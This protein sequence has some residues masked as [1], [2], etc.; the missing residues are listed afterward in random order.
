[1]LE[2]IDVITSFEFVIVSK[3]FFSSSTVPSATNVS[4]VCH[5]FVNVLYWNYSHPA[6]QLEFSV[7]VRP[8]YGYVGVCASKAAD[9]K[10][11]KM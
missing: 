6:E 11:Q 5:N 10:F 3:F 1:M 4:V 8:Y 2:G 7:L 9:K